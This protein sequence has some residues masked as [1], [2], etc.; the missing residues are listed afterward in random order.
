MHAC[1]A[2]EGERDVEMVALLLDKG[3]SVDYVGGRFSMRS[4]HGK[5]DMH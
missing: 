5:V 1:E 2:K 3:A 4:G